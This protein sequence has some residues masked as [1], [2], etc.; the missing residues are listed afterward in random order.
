MRH[1]PA[2]VVPALLLGLALTSLGTAQSVAVSGDTA[3]V[4]LFSVTGSH[5]FVVVRSGATWSLQQELTANDA[6]ILDQFGGSVS[7][8]GDTAL[9][10]AIRC[11]GGSRVSGCV[12]SQ[13]QQ[14]RAPLSVS[15]EDGSL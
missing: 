5:V 10:G 6:A 7:L 9:V 14:R 3:I 11:S 15:L 4:G 8:S 12:A 13:A 1:P 2:T